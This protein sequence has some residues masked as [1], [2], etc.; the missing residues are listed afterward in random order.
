MEGAV[1]DVVSPMLPSGSGLQSM[2]GSWSHLGDRPLEEFKTKLWNE[3]TIN[4]GN[5]QGSRV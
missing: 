1:L 3:L 2:L 5:D 4:S